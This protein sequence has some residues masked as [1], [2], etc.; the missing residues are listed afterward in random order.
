MFFSND[1]GTVPIQYVYI[2]SPWVGQKMSVIHQLQFLTKDLRH[3]IPTLDSID[4]FLP[5]LTCFS[6]GPSFF[7]Q[8][9]SDFRFLS[10]V[11]L[12]T[13]HKSY[14][15]WFSPISPRFTTTLQFLL[16]L[17]FPSELNH[18]QSHLTT[19]VFTLPNSSFIFWVSVT[20]SFST[21]ISPYT[22][23]QKK[24]LPF[25][26]LQNQFTIPVRRDSCPFPQS[27]FYLPN[28]NL[29]SSYGEDNN[30]FPSVFRTA[31]K[32]YQKSMSLSFNSFKRILPQMN[33]L[34]H[35]PFYFQ[36]L[37]FPFKIFRFQRLTPSL[38]STSDTP[39]DLSGYLGQSLVRQKI[40]VIE[41][42]RTP[43]KIVVILR[44]DIRVFPICE[45]DQVP[46]RKQSTQTVLW[47]TLFRQL[48]WSFSHLLTHLVPQIV[49]IPTFVRRVYLHES[50][51]S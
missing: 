33:K 50:L 22:S 36:N 3:Y 1:W 29:P 14:Q 47:V 20:L 4:P 34:L 37:S 26:N 32:S 8:T 38:S 16:I 6:S 43:K 35:L 48:S 13:F 2:S 5:P 31:P 11:N 45:P 21:S 23:S 51:S 18:S 15:P 9:F 17:T 39:N 24:F 42:L 30:G 27:H 46:T 44:T 40:V 7:S 19:P 41:H 28:R 12:L 10:S 49:L 25:L